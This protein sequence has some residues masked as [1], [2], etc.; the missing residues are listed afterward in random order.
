[1]KNGGSAASRML[2]GWMYLSPGI[3]FSE[4]AGSRTL[5][6]QPRFDVFPIFRVE[7]A[8]IHGLPPYARQPALNSDW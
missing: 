1:M 5:A 3:V 6:I 8:L 2:V 4:R 7:S